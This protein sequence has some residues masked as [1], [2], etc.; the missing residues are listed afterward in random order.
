M[1]I[2]LLVLIAGVSAEISS[3]YIAIGKM[4]MF[5]LQDI[6]LPFK[7]IEL[8]KKQASRLLRAV[9]VVFSG[10]KSSFPLGRDYFKEKM[11]EDLIINSIQ[12]LAYS[13]S[14][15]DFREGG[16]EKRLQLPEIEAELPEEKQ[17]FD[18]TSIFEGCKV[19]LYCTH[20]AE[21]YIPDSGKARCEGQRGLINDV[22]RTICES[23]SQQ[24]LTSE[25]EDRIHD[26]PDYNKSYTNSRESVQKILLS[27][28]KLLA[29]F[30]IHRDSIPGLEKAE[31]VEINGKKTARILIIV[32]TD[33]RKSH[34][35]W[36]DNLEFAQEIYHR[37][38]K[39]YPGLIKGVR[40]KAGTYNQEFFPRSLLLEFGGDLNTLAE[41]RY[42]GI[43]FAD[44]LIE[45]LK[46]EL[47]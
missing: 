45:M 21:S 12:A 37:G 10:E 23:I 34:P 39:K 11:P 31:T 32:G 17:D 6:W 3:P 38:E 26:Y 15:G 36:R 4:P 44:I 29:L 43:L 14:E 13:R 42:A 9:N 25:F 20:S 35:D 16:E 18:N 47:E 28:N 7:N 24:G 40:T 2:F 33:E 27:Q 19:V 46:E 5:K 1:Q 30:D 41:A 22:A 8:D